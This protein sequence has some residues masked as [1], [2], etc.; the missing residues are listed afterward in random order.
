MWLTSESESWLEGWESFDA[1]KLCGDKSMLSW[2]CEE[3][4]TSCKGCDSSLD[5]SLFNGATSDFT[6]F[7]GRE[8]EES[9]FLRNCCNAVLGEGLGVLEISPRLPDQLKQ[10]LSV[11]RVGG[12]MVLVNVLVLK[13]WD[14]SAITGTS[15]GICS[16]E[17]CDTLVSPNFLSSRQSASPA[18][19]SLSVTAVSARGWLLAFFDI[20][21]AE[22]RELEKNLTEKH[23]GNNAEIFEFAHEGD[24]IYNGKMVAS[25]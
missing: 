15:S 25:F 22:S 7:S 20:Q 4:P 17:L 11:P 23:N 12:E 8:V 6:V 1:F 24:N 5:S 2:D 3:Q 10:L 13:D 14:S 21:S 9:L 19:V 18:S 16:L